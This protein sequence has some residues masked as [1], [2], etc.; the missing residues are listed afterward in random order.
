MSCQ[1]NANPRQLDSLR[2]PG[3]QPGTYLPRK[4]HARESLDASASAYRSS[5]AVHNALEKL[6]DSGYAVRTCDKPRKYSLAATAAA[7]TQ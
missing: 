2:C 4:L 7:P 1:R 6:G 3:R 5:G